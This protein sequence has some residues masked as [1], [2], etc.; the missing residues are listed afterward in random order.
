[1]SMPMQSGVAQPGEQK[2]FDGVMNEIMGSL[3][4]GPGP[5]APPLEHTA[6]TPKPKTVSDIDAF[7]VF[8]D[9]MKV[10]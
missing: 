10:C 3:A 2:G 5:A 1:M 7:S 9:G 4:T 6:I 8:Q